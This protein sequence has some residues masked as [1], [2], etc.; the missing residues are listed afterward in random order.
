[1]SSAVVVVLGQL[2]E[3][4]SESQERRSPLILPACPGDF[5]S[6]NKAGAERSQKVI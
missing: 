6:E 5:I 2:A 1:M 3:D 4:S